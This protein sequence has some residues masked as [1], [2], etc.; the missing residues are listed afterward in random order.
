MQKFSVASLELENEPEK[1]NFQARILYSAKLSIRQPSRAKVFSN[2]CDPQLYSLISNP[3]L[4][5]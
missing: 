1:K 2:K 3:Y 4:K 5:V